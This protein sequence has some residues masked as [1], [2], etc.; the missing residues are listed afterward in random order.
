VGSGAG[1]TQF[2]NK[3][4]DFGAS[5]AAMTDEEI[6]RVDRG[7]QLLP[8]TAGSIVLAYNLPD[9]SQPL[10]LSRKTYTDIFLGRIAKWNDPALAATNPGVKLPNLNIGVV[11]RADS[12]GTTF[13]F[14]QHLSAISNEWKDGPG[15]S[16]RRTGRPG[17]A[18]RG[19]RA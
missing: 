18:P 19:T 17:L 5:D 15:T 6:A 9:V 13:V 10:R 16:G 7:V 1:V 14:T 12:S 8:M 4:V 2:T 3:T 11:Y